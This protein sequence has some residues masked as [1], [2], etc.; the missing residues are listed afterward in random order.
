MKA[1]LKTGS[2]IVSFGAAAVGPVAESGDP[3]VVFE[4]D[5]EDFDPGGSQPAE[6]RSGDKNT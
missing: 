2:T 4:G 6:A 5:F 3:Q 1:K